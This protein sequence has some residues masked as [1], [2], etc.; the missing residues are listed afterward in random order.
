M[1][2]SIIARIDV[3]RNRQ[4]GKWSGHHDWGQGDCSSPNVKP[5][6]KIAVLTEEVG[7]VAR[8]ALDRNDADLIDELVQVA[9]V[10]IAWLELLVNE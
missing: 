6:T 4:R 8:A 5:M 3:E 1:R 2:T 10:A 7:E 9:A